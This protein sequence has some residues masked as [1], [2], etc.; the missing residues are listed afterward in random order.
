MANPLKSGIRKFIVRLSNVFTKNIQDQQ[1]EIKTTV[2]DG[3]NN[4]ENELNVLESIIKKN[5]GVVEQ[6]NELATKVETISDIAKANFDKTKESTL[7]VEA[8]RHAS[9]YEEAFKDHQPLISIRIATYNRS[10]V[11][12][13][14]AIASILKQSYDNFEVIIVGDHCTDDTAERISKLNDPRFMFYNLP[15]RTVYPEDRMQKW[16]AIGAP[17]MNTAAGLA[18]GKWIAPIDDDD[19]FE[20]DHLK[21]LLDLALSSKCEFVYGAMNQHNLVTGEVK[22]IWAS[23]PQ[24]GGISLNGSLYLKQLDNIFKYDFHSYLLNEPADWNMVRRMMESGVK[25]A[26]IEEIVGTLNMIPPGDKSKDY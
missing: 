12:I 8:M 3:L 5:D 17:A 7:E 13:E 24:L 10:E 6:I 9:I 1:N 14:N 26:S 16:M 21:K 11:L 23:P 18:S 15:T 2:T 4:I 20:E 22:K 19:L 25:I